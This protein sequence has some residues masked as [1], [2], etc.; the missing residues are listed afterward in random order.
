[1]TALFIIKFGSDGIKTVLAVPFEISSLIWSLRV[2]KKK[3]KVQYLFKILADR[4]RSKSLY[5]Q[6]RPT[7]LQ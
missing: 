6:S 5:I 7:Y 1:M 4:Q 2:N 3:I